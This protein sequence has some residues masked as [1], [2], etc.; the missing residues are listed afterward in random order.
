MAARGSGLVSDVGLVFDD[1][2][3]HH[4]TG[5][6]LI[7][8]VEPYPFAVP[9]PHVS[10]PA[11][12]GRAKHLLDF[13]GVTD[14]L[15][16]V[17]PYLADD[18]A[19]LV[20]HTPAHLARVRELD[21]TGGDTGDGAPM[22]P[23]G[24]RVARLAAGGVMAAVDAVATGRLRAVHSLNRPPGHHAMA[25]K[26]MGFCVF[27]NVVVAARHAQR[28]HGL[29][30][31]LILDWDVHHGNGTQDAFYED[32]SVI[33][34]SLHQDNLYPVGWGAADQTGRGAGEGF[35]VNIP[36]PAGTGW[37]GY[38]LAFEQVVLPIARQFKPD[39]VIVSAG[40]DAS[41]LDPLGRMALTTESYRR[42]TRHMVSIAD[43]CAGG[44]IVTVQEG[45][46]SET[47]APYC[48]ATIVQSLFNDQ[49]AG[50]TIPETYY[51][52]A[53]SMPAATRLGLD[54]EAAVA[55]AVAA[56]SNYWS[57]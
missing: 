8:E 40:Q 56:Q 25:G 28:R 7:E 19:L 48:T 49:P 51:D 2:F 50:E 17:D 29:K 18:A 35:T 15:V 30:R 42:M 33:F 46:Y 44:R 41:V 24:E 54:A 38:G 31:V 10:S 21:K 5:L 26:G 1:R 14:R 43:E 45:G 6:A 4:N 52:R 32:D 3:L 53:A 55:A 13:H 47:Y 57:M 9:V 36:L 20:Y 27:N 11:L 23:G 16:R 39:L 12:V 22:G 34:F 37:M